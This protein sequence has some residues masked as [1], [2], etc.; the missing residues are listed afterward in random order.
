MCAHSPPLITD[1]GVAQGMGDLWTLSGT[2]SDADAP[3]TGLTI[4]FGGAFASYHVS[5]TAESDGTFSLTDEFPGLQ[6]G[7]ATAQTTDIN[8]VPSNQALTYVITET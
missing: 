2:V 3:V 1:F 4:I 8:G 7:I 6:T 5:A